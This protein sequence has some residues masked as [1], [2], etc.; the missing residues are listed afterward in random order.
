MRI[1]V[2]GG[3]GFIGRCLVEELAKAGHELVNLDLCRPEWPAPFA[4][5]FIGDVRDRELVREAMSGCSA[6]FHLAAAHHDVG[7]DVPTYFDVNENGTRVLLDVMDKQDVLELCFVSSVA[8]YGQSTDEPD[9]CSPTFPTLPY[10]ASK[11]AAE[12]VAREWAATDPKRSALVLRPAVVFGPHNF[13]NMY[14]LIRQL[15]SRRFVQVGS[16]FN[17]K[18][19]CHVDNLVAAMLY[20]WNQRRTGTRTF[21]YVDKPDLASRQITDVILDALGQRPSRLR[22]PIGLALAAIA[23]VDFLGRMIGR[24]FPISGLRI[25]KFANSRTV[26]DSSAIFRTGFVAPLSLEDGLRSMV[27]WYLG[28]GRKLSPVWRIPPATWQSSSTAAQVVS[29]S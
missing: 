8:V 3:S 22:I 27:N 15:H 16:G 2:T 4:R 28:E 29:Q 7:I 21:N 24:D 11:L 26:F 23:P 20:L 25:R 17:Q 6:V 10:G 9:E 18:S 13:A 14:A 1:L 12:K 5:S 19:M